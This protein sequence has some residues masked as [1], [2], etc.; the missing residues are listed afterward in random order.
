MNIKLHFPT[1]SLIL[2]TSVALLSACSP[3]SELP[4]GYYGDAAVAPPPVSSAPAAY[5]SS[6]HQTNVVSRQNV[7]ISDEQAATQRAGTTRT[8][9]TASSETISKR[10]KLKRHS[11]T[12]E[13]IVE[14]EQATV[15]ETLSVPTSDQDL[16]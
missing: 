12:T 6:L 5:S 7:P 1:S 8:R 9:Q 3:R 16:Q 14:T 4:S 2:L 13:E 11:N 10:G 15:V